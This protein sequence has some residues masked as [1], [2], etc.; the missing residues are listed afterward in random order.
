MGGAKDKIISQFKT[1]TSKDYGKP[2]HFKNV[3]GG[4]KKPNKLKMQ[5]QSEGNILD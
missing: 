4:E 3:Y 1:D 5:K 2:T